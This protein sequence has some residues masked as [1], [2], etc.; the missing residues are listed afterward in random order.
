MRRFPWHV[1]G[2]AVL[3]ALAL[4]GLFLVTQPAQ[5]D[6]SPSVFVDR[7]PLPAPVYQHGV[8]GDGTYFYVIG[9]QAWN[10]SSLNTVADV[11]R[12]DPAADSYTARASLPAEPRRVCHERQDL[13]AGWVQCGRT[14]L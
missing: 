1:G 6:R 2:L 7:T 11:Y 3:T 9:G 10:G 13:C 4:S 8:A 14:T 5:A 12:Y